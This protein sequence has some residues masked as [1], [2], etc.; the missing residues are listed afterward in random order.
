MVISRCGLNAIITL[1]CNDLLF[2]LVDYHGNRISFTLVRLTCSDVS[3]R[4]CKFVIAFHKNRLIA[5]E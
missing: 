4:E 3:N 2:D 1:C 5:V